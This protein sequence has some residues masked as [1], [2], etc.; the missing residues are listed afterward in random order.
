VSKLK[1]FFYPE[2]LEEARKILVDESVKTG[3]IAGG[4]SVSLARDSSLE[5]LVD[6]TRMKINSITEE[7]GTFFVGAASTIHDLQ[8]SK[9]VKSIGDGMVSYAASLIASR[10]L[11]N[12]ITLGGNIAQ[13]KN[14]SDMPVVLMTL[15]A[16]VRVTGEDE[17]IVSAW[18]FFKDHP[19]KLLKPGEIVTEIIFPKPPKN[20]VCD[21]IKFAKTYGDY[22]IATVGTYLEFKEGKCVEAR[23]VVGAVHNLP[24]LLREVEEILEG[25]EITPTLIDK[26][27]KAAR[28]EVKTVSNLWGTAE[29][30]KDVVENLVRTSLTNTFEKAGKKR[31]I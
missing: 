15:D 6:I 30:K 1:Q 23:I 13:L 26:A 29:Y 28:E 10:P 17:E 11:R 5:A 31:I 4:T 27:A 14:W 9:P 2:T 20:A 8:V 7:N 21:Y 25:H 16:S 12:V 3:I 18:E 19:Q 22:A 24:Q